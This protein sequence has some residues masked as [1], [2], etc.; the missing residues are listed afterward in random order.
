[1]TGGC[2]SS[3]TA[4]SSFASAQVNWTSA[5]MAAHVGFHASADTV[6]IL[7]GPAH[8]GDDHCH[9][10]LH[11]ALIAR[12]AQLRQLVRLGPLDLGASL[13]FAPGH[14]AEWHTDDLP[15]RDLLSKAL[16]AF[17]LKPRKKFC[18]AFVNVV[19]HSTVSA[20]GPFRVQALAPASRPRLA[21]AAS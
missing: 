16:L 6:G 14:D 7:P 3:R 2:G 13:G 4:S 9:V 10:E 15:G 18:L 1:M 8:A 21:R 11:L 19:F 12:G 5:G 17:G 20:P